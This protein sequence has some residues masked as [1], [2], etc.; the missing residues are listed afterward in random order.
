[1]ADYSQII[2]DTVRQGGDKAVVSDNLNKLITKIGPNASPAYDQI[3]AGANNY[4][5]NGVNGP[6]AATDAEILKMP[7]A[8]KPV[9]KPG[10][11]G[12]DL[13]S[14]SSSGNT[15]DWNAEI[16]KAAP[17]EVPFY[18]ENLEVIDIAELEKV[19]F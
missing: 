11:I 14:T 19:I 2:K 1:M 3:I 17:S 5:Q 9:P 4:L 8:M 7:G 18:D 10:D 12:N 13:G 6:R 16:K 15:I